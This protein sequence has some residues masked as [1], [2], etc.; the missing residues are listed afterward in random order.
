M[1]DVIF[2]LNINIL[3]N[4]MHDKC[5]VKISKNDLCL[6]FL[7]YYDF[8]NLFLFTLYFLFCVNT[9]QIQ[10]RMKRLNK[11]KENRH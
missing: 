8:D 7:L 3:A 9:L 6:L 4:E 11:K 10:I 5:Y 2:F 1:N